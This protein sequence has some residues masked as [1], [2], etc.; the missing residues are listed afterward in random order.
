[1]DGC[2]PVNGAS[3][4]TGWGSPPPPASEH[5]ALGLCLLPF[6]P[7]SPHCF[8]ICSSLLIPIFSLETA[9]VHSL[10]LPGREGG[11]WAMRFLGNCNTTPGPGY[12]CG[13][14]YQAVRHKHCSTAKRG[15]RS[16]QKHDIALCVHRVYR[17]L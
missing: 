7:P 10:L 3:L 15:Q 17:A 13:G 5:R 4:L 11:T 6:G 9:G 12:C 14:L 16:G 8:L 1:M 2:S